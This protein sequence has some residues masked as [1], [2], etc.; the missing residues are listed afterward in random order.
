M[1]VTI[2][3]NRTLVDHAD[4]TTGWSSP[5]GSESLNQFT[6]DPDP[7]E[8]TGCIGMAVSTETADL[9]HTITSV[10]LSDVILYV[11]V[12][13]NGTM[14]IADNGGIAP[15]LGD[16]TDLIGYNLL[17]SDIAGFRHN[18][19]PVGWQCIAFDV[20]RSSTLVSQVTELEGT[21]AALDLAAITRVGIQ[22][23]T[24]SKALGGAS[25]CFTDTIR[26]DSGSQGI[27]MTAG[28]DADPGTF[29]D[30]AAA[31][32]STLTATAYG[33]LR[34]LGSGLYGCQ[35]SMTFGDTAGTA[36]SLFKDKNSTVVFEDRN[37]APSRYKFTIQGNS[38]G[39]TTFQLGTKVGTDDGVDGGTI[40]VPLGVG[41]EWIASDADLDFLL[42]Y[43]VTIKGFV[44]GVTF[45]SDAT[46]GPNHE[47]FGNRFVN[48]G[49]IDAGEA[50]YKNNTFVDS[51]GQ[52]G[53]AILLLTDEA[54]TANLTFT[55]QGI[56]YDLASV[57]V[58]S[59]EQYSTISEDTQPVG[60]TWATSGSNEGKRFYILGF[61]G[62]TLDEYSVS[63]AW[64]LSSTVAF[65]SNSVSVS[66]TD[67]TP[68][69]VAWNND[70]TKFFVLG[71]TSND[72]H[73]YTVSTGWDL[74]STVT[75]TSNNSGAVTTD[76][77]TPTGLCFD[78][79]GDNFYVA[80][81]DNNIVYQYSMSTSFDMGS[82]LADTTNTLDVSTQTT[83]P[84]TIQFND[85]GFV[86][87]VMDSDAESLFG[88][89]LTTAYDIS[90]ATYDDK[91]YSFTD[92]IGNTNLQAFVFGDD[93]K[94]IFIINDGGLPV[95]GVQEYWL[96]V[97]HGIEINPTGAGPFTYDLDNYQFLG[98]ATADGSIG[99]ECIFV[100]PSTLSADVNINILNGG[101]APSIHTVTSYTGTVT[102][103]NAQPLIIEGLTEGAAVKVIANETV[104]SITTGDTIL[105]GLANSSGI[106]QDLSFNYESAF[107]PSGLDVVVRARS[108]GLPSAAIQ[109]D[110][111]AFT[112]QTTNANSSTINDMNLL[113][114]T[115]VSGQDRYIFGHSEQF[116]KLKIDISTVG[117]GGFTI[118]WQY[119]NGAWTNL[120]SVTDGTSSF[121]VADESE[122][123]WTLPGDWVTTTINSQGPYYFVRAAYTA[124]TV[125]IT[126]LGRKVK[127]D[128]TRYLPFN[129]NRTIAS[130]GLTVV[131]SWIEDTIA[132]F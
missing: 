4:A 14:D 90:T 65:T 2:T 85:D 121:S 126:P 102:V 80:G 108:S 55:T 89:I 71:N 67:A 63:V 105:E 78:D 99:N 58:N 74:S 45:S 5:V 87:V 83:N 95:V 36:A 52:D 109:D 93:G 30:I 20:S 18:T 86:F 12:L 10:D 122:V 77:G 107:N 124:G 68:T 16:V 33:I 69:D 35:G 94:K 34:E 49:I 51:I 11:W 91:L 43:G 44:N 38:T 56:P 123:S 79:V 100:N 22:Y 31:D 59:K 64:D 61:T 28:T 132:S 6:S 8:A 76:D 127:L 113:P 103:T 129:Q 66:G 111:A 32:R 47:I 23:K 13:A 37:F 119:W 48:C 7:V 125:T 82:T 41:G 92:D 24:L 130:N 42:L 9:I 96:N 39:E 73:E 3:D 62:T 81:N 97:K 40:E 25:N 27:T 57:I 120:S 50:Q 115:P 84:G 54:G 60:I 1:A 106:V 118:T 19:G 29:S 101:T 17:G 21:L 114:T 70:G 104:G 26:Y 112:D 131:A 116:D 117:T 15:I 110:N 75:S 53:G 128:V 72:V 46:N 88:Y 98:F